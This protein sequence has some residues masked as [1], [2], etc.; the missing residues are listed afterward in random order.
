MLQTDP[1][2]KKEM[3]DW[4]VELSPVLERIL[5]PLLLL[6]TSRTKNSIIIKYLM[7]IL[8]IMSFSTEDNTVFTK[9]LNSSASNSLAFPVIWKK[10]WEKFHQMIGNQVQSLL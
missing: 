3:S 5:D 7:Q 4:Q 9:R 1:C 10:Q 2:S 6:S 8:Q